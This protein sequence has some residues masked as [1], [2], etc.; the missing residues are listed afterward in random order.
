MLSVTVLAYSL[1]L[2]TFGSTKDGPDFQLPGKPPNSQQVVGKRQCWNSAAFALTGALEIA[3]EKFTGSAIKLSEQEILDC[4]HSGC[5]ELTAPTVTNLVHWLKIQDRLAPANSYPEFNSKMDGDGSSCR[6]SNAPNALILDLELFFEITNSEIEKNLEKYG[7]I[8]AKINIYP[9]HCPGYLKLKSTYD[10]LTK[11]QYLDIYRDNDEDGFLDGYLKW[12]TGENGHVIRGGEPTS[13]VTHNVLIVGLY[14]DESGTE[15]YEVRDS[16]GDTWMRRGHFLIERHSNMCGIETQLL[17]LKM[18][19][20]SEKKIGCPADFP[21]LCA[22]TRTCTKQDQDCVAQGNDYNDYDPK[23]NAPIKTKDLPDVSGRPECQDTAG[24]EELCTE[25]AKVWRNCNSAAIQKQCAGSCFMCHRD[26]CQDVE[27]TLG[28]CGNYKRYCNLLPA[29]MAMCPKTC[30]M[31]PL[32]CGTL[33]ENIELLVG[34]KNQPTGQCYLPT[35]KNGAALNDGMLEAGEK[36][37]IQCDVGFELSGE[38][39]YCVIQNMFGPDSRLVQEC[40]AVGDETWTGTGGNYQGPNKITVENTPC[41]NAKEVAAKGLHDVEGLSVK[42]GR[43]ALKGSNSNYCR[44]HD[45]VGFAPWCVTFNIDLGYFEGL[46]LDFGAGAEDIDTDEQIKVSNAEHRYCYELPAC[47]GDFCAFSMNLLG[48]FMCGMEED[49]VDSCSLSNVAGS[50]QQ[51]IC[52][53]FCCQFAS[54]CEE[55][56]EEVQP[57]GTTAASSH[58]SSFTDSISPSDSL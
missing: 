6:A 32:D 14:T 24:Y 15:Y 1:A 33:Y 34:H 43:A 18:S 25:K 17:V 31:H 21:K 52:T 7:S 16:R 9:E 45:D 11:T 38:E 40:V 51:E 2:L 58:P 35:I 39:S 8:F 42:F 4:H 50:S 49:A 29:V 13:V 57:T 46:E 23:G 56:P 12:F 26:T 36:L 55:T 30:G 48:Q 41:A 54:Q 20:K 10:K 19:E 3:T 37:V 47:G 28:E 44:N 22:D 27:E 5:S 53:N